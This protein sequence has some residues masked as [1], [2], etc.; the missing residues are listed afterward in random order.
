MSS[1]PKYLYVQK[2]FN[3]Q[4]VGDKTPFT[5]IYTVIQLMLYVVVCW[6]KM[7]TGADDVFKFHVDGPMSRKILY[8]RNKPEIAGACIKY[9]TTEDDR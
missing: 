1:I 8:Y 3:F 9:K 7:K 4:S 5:N 6:R 2:L